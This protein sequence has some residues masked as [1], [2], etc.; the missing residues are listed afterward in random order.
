MHTD[1]LVDKWINEG[2][3]SCKGQGGSRETIKDATLVN[4]W[5]SQRNSQ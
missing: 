2:M 3:N 1:N 5:N 4:R